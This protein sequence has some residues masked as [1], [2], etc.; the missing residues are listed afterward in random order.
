MKRLLSVLLLI[1]LLI[2]AVGCGADKDLVSSVPQI[3]EPTHDLGLFNSTTQSNNAQTVTSSENVESVISSDTVDETESQEDTYSQE[4]TADVSSETSSQEEV[5]SQADTESSE[6][7]SV[8]SSSKPSSKP[9]KWANATVKPSDI[10]NPTGL[11]SVDRKDNSGKDWQ[12]TLVNPWN[13]LHTSYQINVAEVDSRFGAGKLFD[14]RA[15]GDLNAMCEAALEDGV[16]L[17][18]ISAHRTYDYQQ[19][20]YNNEVAEYKAYHPG[21]SEDEAL[22]GAATEVARP[23]TS[24]HNLGLAVDFNS[25]EQNF[26]DTEA[27]RW[28]NENCTEYG[29]ILRYSTSTQD[30]TGVIYEPWHY[31]YV[32]K[33]NA[34]K[35]KASGLT[36]EEYVKA[37]G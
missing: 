18:V 19:M 5:S 16:S 15:V 11:V 1:S 29:F 17:S 31:R 28:L 35:I 21:C 8:V 6:V 22:K 13:T 4:D 3:S 20:L 27:F 23:G 34:K 33:E 2:T 10:K 36:L 9:D 32:G 30:I 12:L 37:N 7:S 24:E 14:A 25:V 26:E